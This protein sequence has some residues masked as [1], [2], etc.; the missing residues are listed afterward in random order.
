MKELL[1]I[2][3]IW[4][5][6]QLLLKYYLMIILKQNIFYYINYIDEFDELIN[7]DIIILQFPGGIPGI[8]NGK[9]KKINNY[10]FT[11][12]IEIGSSGSPI[13]LE[14]NTQFI[15]INK[16]EKKNKMKKINPKIMEILLVLYIIILKIFH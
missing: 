16:S 9:I 12:S 15:R 5:L 13:F 4:T 8:S 3:Q 14:N 6:M 11:A 7:K 1:K 10:E 2:L